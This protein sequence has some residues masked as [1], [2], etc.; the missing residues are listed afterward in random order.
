MGALTLK[1]NQKNIRFKY[2]YHL[3][4]FLYIKDLSVLSGNKDKDTQNGNLSIVYND[5]TPGIDGGIK[6]FIQNKNYV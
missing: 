1:F 3:C 6:T 5:S 4:F 2:A